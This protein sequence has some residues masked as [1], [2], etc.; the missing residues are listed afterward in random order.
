MSSKGFLKLQ[1]FA[2]IFTLIILMQVSFPGEL[3]KDF[4]YFHC[5]SVSS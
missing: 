4:S 3:E 2:K 5:L 1:V